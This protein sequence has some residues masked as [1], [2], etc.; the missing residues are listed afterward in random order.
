MQGVLPASSATPLL[1]RQRARACVRLAFTDRL[2]NRMQVLNRVI[3]HAGLEGVPPYTMEMLAGVQG[4]VGPHSSSKHSTE[5]LETTSVL[6][7]H[8]EKP[9]RDLVTLINAYW[10]ARDFTGLQNEF[11]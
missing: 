4:F 9:Q 8:F 1:V 6:R 10:P 5:V 3:K 11:R 7:Q 2:Q